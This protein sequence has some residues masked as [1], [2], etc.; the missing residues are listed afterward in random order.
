MIRPRL[1]DFVYN[2]EEINLMI[3]DI[4]HF[5]SMGVEGFLLGALNSDK[6]LNM[7]A[8]KKVS[9]PPVIKPFMSICL[10]KKHQNQRKH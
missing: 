10:G 4:I 6:T 9:M 5:R 8:I 2:R 7:D 1:G 3:T